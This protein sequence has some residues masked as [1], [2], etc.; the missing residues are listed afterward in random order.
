MDLPNK[1]TCMILAEQRQCS[2]VNTLQ[3]ISGKVKLTSMRCSNTS[4]GDATQR[5]SLFRIDVT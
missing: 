1:E 3:A 4:Q 5:H 2:S